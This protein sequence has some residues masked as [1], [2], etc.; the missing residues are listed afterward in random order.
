MK[1]LFIEICR[2]RPIEWELHLEWELETLA[3]SNWMEVDARYD[4]LN[5]A[6]MNT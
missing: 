4:E 3:I 1:T 5:S 2:F 6:F